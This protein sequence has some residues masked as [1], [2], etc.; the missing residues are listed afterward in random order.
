VCFWLPR[1]CRT[2]VAGRHYGGCLPWTAALLAA[3]AQRSTL[4]GPRQTLR[5]CRSLVLRIALIGTPSFCTTSQ[6]ARN[7]RNM[8]VGALPPPRRTFTVPGLSHPL[9][10]LQ[11]LYRRA[12]RHAVRRE[13]DVGWSGKSAGTR[14]PPHPHYPGEGAQIVYS[15]PPSTGS[16]QDLQRPH[17]HKWPSSTPSVGRSCWHGP[18]G[19]FSPTLL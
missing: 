19:L 12:C 2:S 3:C 4:C 13:G 1:D 5:L 9:R 17:L 14:L 7:G 18:F 11:F 8:A 15:Y 6:Q 16:L 10:H